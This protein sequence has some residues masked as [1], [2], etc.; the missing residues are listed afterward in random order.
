MDNT[1]ESYT[2]NEIFGQP[3]LW[4]KVFDMLILQKDEIHQ[5]L[6]PILK[7]N[8]LRII[9]TGAG[10]SAFIGEA[11][12][13]I[14]ELK[15]G[16]ITQA[17]ATTDL[18]TEYKVFAITKK[19]ILLVS[20]ARSGNSPESSEVFSLAERFCT[21]VYHL[22]ITC[23]KSGH[24]ANCSTSNPNS[25]YK[26]ILPVEANDKSL[27]MTGSFTSMLICLLLLWETNG[28]ENKE[29]EIDDMIW[30]GKEILKKAPL[31]KEICSEK[32]HR[33]VFLGSGPLLGIA[34]ECH[35][36]LQELTNGQI[37]CKFDSFLGFRHGPMAVMNENTLMVYLFSNDNHTYKYERDLVKKIS[38]DHR[39]IKSISVNNR[40]GFD[41]INSFAICERTKNYSE[42][43]IVPFAIVGQLL[44]LY[45]SLR[46]DLNP[47]NPST[48]GTINRIVQGV[49]I[50]NT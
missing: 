21:E 40:E 26:I 12:Q 50:Y 19:P 45:S 30:L 27:A 36:K 24:L 11:A 18:T 23:D 13:S 4:K 22:I 1:K 29:K 31:I 25:F 41:A 49:T 17:I 16:K 14:I 10:S 38:K 44:G 39:N 33:A 20:I 35:L 15:T 28:I 43:A 42:L 34:R 32:F 7:I 5:F 48:N 47:D 46:L 2:V 9:L 37:I 6:D 8:D 3:I